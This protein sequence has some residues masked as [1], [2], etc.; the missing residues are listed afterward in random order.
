MYD[1][2]QNQTVNK[3]KG[4]DLDDIKNAIYSFAIYACVPAALVGYTYY[5]HKQ[6]VKFYETGELKEEDAA[7]L[8]KRLT[9]FYNT[10]AEL[11]Y[12]ESHQLNGRYRDFMLQRPNQYM[13][14]QQKLDRMNQN[15]EMLNAL[16][17]KQ[18]NVILK[19]LT[20]LQREQLHISKIMPPEFLYTFRQGKINEDIDETSIEKLIKNLFLVMAELQKDVEWQPS[21]EQLSTAQKTYE[22]YV[23]SGKLDETTQQEVQKRLHNYFKVAEQKYR[24]SLDYMKENSDGMKI[25]DPKAAA[26]LKNSIIQMN[27]TTY[28]YQ[29]ENLKN[30]QVTVKGISPSRISILLK[31]GSFEDFV[32]DTLGHYKE[33]PTNYPHA[34]DRAIVQWYIAETAGKPI[35]DD[36]LVTQERL[37]KEQADRDAILF[38]QKFTISQNEET[39][40]AQQE[41]ISQLRTLVNQ[42]Q[43]TLDKQNRRI[44][45]LEGQRA[46]SRRKAEDA[47]IGGFVTG[48]VLGH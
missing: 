45:E 3:K 43:S 34:T 13:I 18:E 30:P 42:Q 8:I 46:Q 32:N 2:N 24:H 40:A 48:R 16:L 19:N 29:A 44:E 12:Q 4:F 21:K 39:I 23:R 6:V 47:A 10:I 11:I 1:E 37:R 22:N 14:L 33:H 17:Q 31:D 36:Y 9:E 26:A 41:E 5:D 28:W 27:K 38:N 7:P 20:P 15:V 35:I 25:N